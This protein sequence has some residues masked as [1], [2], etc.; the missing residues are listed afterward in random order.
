[1]Y[2]AI[3]SSSYGARFEFIR[4]PDPTITS[5]DPKEG[6]AGATPLMTVT[7]TNFEAP[8]TVQFYRNNT[9]TDGVSPMVQNST[10]I[11][12]TVPGTL[13]VGTYYIVVARQG[14]NGVLNSR[15][16]YKVTAP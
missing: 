2:S 6:P 1:M 16:Y 11:K 15:V 5:I 9:L 12:V 14:A 3:I 4:L 13:A 7:G 10:T 8:M